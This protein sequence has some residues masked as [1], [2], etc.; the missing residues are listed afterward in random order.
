[1]KNETNVIE[2]LATPISVTVPYPPGFPLNTNL[3]TTLQGVITFNHSRPYKPIQPLV[4]AYLE[5]VNNKKNM[6]VS[7]VFFIDAK[8]PLQEVRVQ[9]EFA[10]S[11]MGEPTLQFFICYDL[12]ETYGTTFQANQISFEAKMQG[13]PSNLTFADIKTIQVFL[14]DTDPVSSRGTVTNVQS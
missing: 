14:W 13:N 7:V 11:D 4:E 6:H 8:F 2:P 10:I 3:A 12:L 1:M 5:T 9:Q